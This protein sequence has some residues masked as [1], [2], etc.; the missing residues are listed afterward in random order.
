MKNLAVED[1]DDLGD[2][3]IAEQPLEDTRSSAKAK[4]E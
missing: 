3:R 4:L 1:V 2:L